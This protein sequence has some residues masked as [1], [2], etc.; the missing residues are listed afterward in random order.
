MAVVIVTEDPANQM[1]VSV[2]LQGKEYWF[3]YLEQEVA[4]ANID[5][6]TRADWE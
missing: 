6:A 2:Q 3:T 4:D 1:G 5:E